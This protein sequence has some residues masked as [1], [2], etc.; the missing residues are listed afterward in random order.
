[1]RNL[2]F[3]TLIGF[4]FLGLPGQGLAEP[5]MSWGWWQPDVQMVLKWN[6]DETTTLRYVPTGKYISK[7][8]GVPPKTPGSSSSALRPTARPKSGFMKGWI[9]APSP[10]SFPSVEASVDKFGQQRIPKE[11]LYK[12]KAMAWGF[13]HEMVDDPAT[14]Q[15]M[16]EVW[17]QPGFDLDMAEAVDKI[18]VTWPGKVWIPGYGPD[19]KYVTTP[20]RPAT[21]W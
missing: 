15:V 19:I 4:A 17:S 18:P 5:E 12:M 16:R 1:M 13:A 2:F 3:R 7:D 8:T 9:W 20:V 14:W 21:D 11:E 10:Q 6:P